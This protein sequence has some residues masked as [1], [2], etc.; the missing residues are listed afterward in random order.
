MTARQR[1]ETLE[2]PRSKTR[3]AASRGRRV[4]PHVF[5]RCILGQT[6]DQSILAAAVPVSAGARIVCLIVDLDLEAAIFEAEVAPERGLDAAREAVAALARRRRPAP[7]LLT[8]MA[9]EAE[10]PADDQIEAFA[11]SFGSVSG[12]VVEVRSMRGPGASQAPRRS[13]PWELSSASP[14]APARV[15]IECGPPT[16][17]L[18]VCVEGVPASAVED[19]CR[20]VG[21]ADTGLADVR[22]CPHASARSGEPIIVLELFDGRSS[23]LARCMALL[24]VEAR[25]CGGH[26]AK[27]RLLSHVPLD[28]LLGTLDARLGLS[29]APRQVLETHLPGDVPFVPKR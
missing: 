20:A 13:L 3:A 24:E 29:I 28:W 5:L 19:I 11:H 4:L 26:V 23:S 27:A 14:N 22:A 7:T 9:P 10:L 25:R 21:G 8:L 18:A 16:V 17:L 12:Q 2:Y 15:I 1:L 6:V